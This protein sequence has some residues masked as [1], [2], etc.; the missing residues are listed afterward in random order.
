MGMWHFEMFSASKGAPGE[1]ESFMRDE[2]LPYFRSRGFQV[3]FFVTQH[4]LGKG[5][6]FFATEAPTFAHL[7][8]W[9]EQVAGEP[10]G[11]ELLTL[12]VS[13]I[14]GAP[15]ASMIREIGAGDTPLCWT[16]NPM[17][18]VERFN[19]NRP[20]GELEEH[21]TQRCLPYWRSRGFTVHVMQSELGLGPR[22]LWLLTGVDRFGSL[23][24]WDERALAEPY[25]RRIMTELI[26]ML[27]DKVANLIRDVEA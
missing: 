16:S 1:M 26:A 3:K 27:R 6:F 10:R 18:H 9:P 17:W 4:E 7:D 23:D 12:L 13:M 15:Q 24:E 2:A 11:A 25:G 8:R 21:L 20:V 5:E 19:S 22:A 14:D